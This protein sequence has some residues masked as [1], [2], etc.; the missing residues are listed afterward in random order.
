MTLKDALQYW[1]DTER[2][3]SWQSFHCPQEMILKFKNYAAGKDT[4]LEN[5][6]FT[7]SISRNSLNFPT[8]QL[9]KME[10]EEV[11]TMVLVCQS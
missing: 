4:W 6:E 2:D 11:N 5:F 8:F 7:P 3:S 9:H 10:F 1:I